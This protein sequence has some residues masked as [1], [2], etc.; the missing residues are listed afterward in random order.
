MISVCNNAIQNIQLQTEFLLNF[1][2]SRPN[3]LS[4]SRKVYIPR[5]FILQKFSYILKSPH[6]MTESQIRRFNISGKLTSYFMPRSQ[7][8]ISK[9]HLFQTCLSISNGPRS[10]EQ[11]RCKY[12]W[13]QARI[14]PFISP[15]ASKYRFACL[16]TNKNSRVLF[17]TRTWS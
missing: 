1:L 11:G 5:K 4:N 6:C 7:K 3:Q 8:G 15:N 16:E 12:E 2:T 17:S 13:P 9:L 14:F 10:C